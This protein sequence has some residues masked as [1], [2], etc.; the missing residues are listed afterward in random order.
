MT[1]INLNTANTRQVLWAILLIAL[2]FRV[3]AVFVSDRRA[4][5]YHEYMVIAQNLIDGKGYSWDEWGRAPLQPTSFLPPLYVYWCVAFQ[6]SLHQDYTLMYI[7]QALVSALG[8]FLAYAVGR[9]MFSRETG[10]IFALFYAAYPEFAA[11]HTRP[12]TEFLYLPLALALILGY[13]ILKEHPFDARGA[14]AALLWGLACG[15][16]VLVKESAVLLIAALGL[17][18]LWSRRRDWRRVVTH[19][20]FPAVAALLVALSPWIIR[21]YIVQH[22]L[23]AIRTGFGVTA[24]IANH[25]GSTGTDK[26]LDGSYVLATQDST[27]SEHMKAVLP[28]DEQDRDK[29]YMAEAK[30]F[31]LENP[32]E[33][34]R[35]TMRRL[36]YFVLFDE[37]HPFAKNLVYRIGW[38]LLLIGGIR[39]GILAKRKGVLDPAIL[40][41]VGL[42]A[43]LYVP[44]LVLPR[45][46]MILALWL[47]ILAAYLVDNLFT[48][49]TR[50]GNT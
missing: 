45:Y 23:I 28:P 17:A 49:I 32:G 46:R 43:V 30:R 20:G 48:R 50:D 31:A 36:Q 34:F 4:E 38:V 2:S 47:L 22:E 35:L 29:L 37:T 44:V 9:K 8:V 33:Y 40:L 12:I 21:N 15:I 6:S 39:G 14:K 13:L 1:R 16:T 3:I 25:P 5:V 10:I 27:Y 24:W 19:I 41:S 18:L 42:L 7:A 26:R 11:Y